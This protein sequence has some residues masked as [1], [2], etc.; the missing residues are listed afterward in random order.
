MER[1]FW[2]DYMGAFEEAIN[3]T[4]TPWAPWYVIPADRKWAMRAC[5]SDIIT[6]TIKSLPLA[7]PTVPA[8]EVAKLA[9]AKA[10]LLAEG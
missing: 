9:E 5:V 8:D 7:Y 3:A 10:A 1:G 4:S 6:T 2:D